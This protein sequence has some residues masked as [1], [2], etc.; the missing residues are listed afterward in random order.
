MKKRVGDRIAIINGAPTAEVFAPQFQSLGVQ[1]YSSAVFTFLPKLARRFFEALRGR[2]QVLVEAMLEGFYNPL[3]E[4]RNRKHGYAVSIVKAGLRVAGK[5]QA[6]CARRSSI[7][8]RRRRRCSPVSLP[9]RRMESMRIATLDVALPR[10]ARLSSFW[11]SR[12][13]CPARR[14]SADG[15][16]RDRAALRHG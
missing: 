2:D 9:G 15:R 16:R 12:T 13:V 5:P 11:I 7:W 8:M 6:P 14:G 3:V 1:S 4:L 10:Q